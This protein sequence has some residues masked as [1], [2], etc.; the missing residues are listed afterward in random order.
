MITEYKDICLVCGAPAAETHHLVF[1]RGIR[2]LAD[3]DGLMVPLCAKCHKEIHYSGTAAAL[4][5]ILGQLQF[6]DE[7]MARA[8]LYGINT[9]EFAR[10]AFRKRYGRSY[11]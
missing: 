9:R 5:K 1:G 6:E 3:E 2:P 11:L 4:S 7:Y 10:E 8:S